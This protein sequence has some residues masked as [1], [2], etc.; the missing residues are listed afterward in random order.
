MFFFVFMCIFLFVVSCPMRSVEHLCSTYLLH[1]YYPNAREIFSASQNVLIDDGGGQTVWNRV[2]SRKTGLPQNTHATERHTAALRPSCRS[3]PAAKFRH[4]G[5]LISATKAALNSPL[6]RLRT[7]R[8][9]RRKPAGART[10][11][12][13]STI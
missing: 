9:S 10:T 3:I 11:A 7:Q 1:I 5:E 13:F 4:S 6:L 12:M 2:E 8:R